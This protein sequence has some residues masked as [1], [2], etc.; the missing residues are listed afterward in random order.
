M[1]RTTLAASPPHSSILLVFIA[2]P[3]DGSLVEYPEL[4]RRAPPRHRGL[5]AARLG[6]TP[7]RTCGEL[8]THGVRRAYQLFVRATASGLRTRMRASTATQRS[9]RASTG[10]RSSS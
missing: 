10:F 5:V 8:R 1:M 7:L 4:R 6:E 3:P 9:G 2:P